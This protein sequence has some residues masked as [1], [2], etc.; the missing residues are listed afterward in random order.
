MKFVTELKN[1]ADLVLDYYSL[2]L[3]KLGPLT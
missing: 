1:A 2:Y 3:E